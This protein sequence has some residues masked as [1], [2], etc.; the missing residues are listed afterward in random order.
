METFWISSEIR[1]LN[2]SNSQVCIAIN[3]KIS[4]GKKSIIVI[5][6][7]TLKITIII[8]FKELKL[9]EDYSKNGKLN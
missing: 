4:R 1:S 5:N 3:K 2:Q 8:K 7:S 6:K 9:L